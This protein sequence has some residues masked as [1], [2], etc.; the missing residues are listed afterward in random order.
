MNGKLYQHIRGTGAFIRQLN[1]EDQLIEKL[2]TLLTESIVDSNITAAGHQLSM[3]LRNINVSN[4][5]KDIGF[6]PSAILSEAPFSKLDQLNLTNTGLGNSTLDIV[7]L[8]LFRLGLLKIGKTAMGKTSDSFIPSTIL[9][10]DVL[11]QE[12]Q[13]RNGTQKDGTSFNVTRL[14]IPLTINE[15]L[16]YTMEYQVRKYVRNYLD[17]LEECYHERSALPSSERDK[18]MRIS[19][20][21]SLLDT[22]FRELINLEATGSW[23]QMWDDS[24]TQIKC[25]SILPVPDRS[26]I[27]WGMAIPEVFKSCANLQYQI[28]HL[29]MA[30]AKARGGKFVDSYPTYESMER[31]GYLNYDQ[32]KGITPE[33]V[34]E[35]LRLSIRDESNIMHNLIHLASFI[36]EAS[37][38]D[39]RIMNTL[40]L[41][42]YS[43]FYSK[44]STPLGGETWIKSGDG[45]QA[46]D[47]LNHKSDLENK[48]V[49]FPTT[50]DYDTTANHS[51]K[52][53]AL[54]MTGL[55]RGMVKGTDQ[56]FTTTL[57]EFGSST[58]R[59]QRI[60]RNVPKNNHWN[61]TRVDFKI[62]DH[63]DAV[64]PYTGHSYGKEWADTIKSLLPAGL[65]IPRVSATSIQNF[66]AKGVKT[67][68]KTSAGSVSAA[69]KVPSSLKSTNLFVI[70]NAEAWYLAAYK[71]GYDT[72]KG[73]FKF[74]NPDDFAS[75][76]VHWL[77]NAENL[78]QHNM[79]W[80]T[81]PEF[82][83]HFCENWEGG[84]SF[85]NDYNTKYIIDRAGYQSTLPSINAHYGGSQTYSIPYSDSEV[86]VEMETSEVLDLPSPKIG[87]HN[88]LLMSQFLQ[89][90][91]A[92]RFNYMVAELAGD[93]SGGVFTDGYAFRIN[94]RFQTLVENSRLVHMDRWLPSTI[95]ATAPIQG[96]LLAE[97]ISD[98]SQFGI[99]ALLDLI[100][101][102]EVGVQ[103]NQEA[104]SFLLNALAEHSATRS[105][106]EWS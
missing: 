99:S 45:L 79:T 21:P 51:A 52:D 80:T 89:S 91:L 12:V 15:M 36:E 32:V 96:L 6:A 25:A 19:G 20:L 2:S 40:S 56:E 4:A 76:K 47:V 101:N 106:K 30:I 74:L 1:K 43:Q 9:E 61:F 95:V 58:L 27:S 98:C 85:M 22:G 63:A 75:S 10:L 84:Q 44:D 17:R 7:A 49:S 42:E 13:S 8:E 83:L 93:A 31:Y 90:M 23:Y 69:L 67:N 41:E 81:N 103:F 87:Y 86:T 37:T 57:V 24:I 50:I 62:T 102:G 29:R 55:G 64:E 38:G 3:K 5:L 65:E 46:F 28:H 70:S 39:D 33:S 104:D 60:Q 18:H 35:S 66:N 77:L 71:G 97:L 11:T 34:A 48:L 105:F 16:R 54:S 68:K 100:N 73:L 88:P 82:V 78:K 14:D 26:L 92:H 94:Q 59:L 72:E 53:I